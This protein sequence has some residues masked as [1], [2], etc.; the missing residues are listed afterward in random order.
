MKIKPIQV[1]LKNGKTVFLRSAVAGDAEAMLTHLVTTHTEAYRNM[2]RT[3]D[4]WKDMST[5]K[6][7]K[8]L[9][10]FES[11]E[12]KFMI[13]ATSEERIIGGLGF[14]GASGQFQQKNGGLGMSIQKEISNSGLGTQMMNL[15]IST[16]KKMGFHR[17]E[18]SVRTYNES[19]IALYEKVGFQ[20]VGTLKEIAFIDNEYVDEFSYQ[21]IL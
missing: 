11:S 6:E 13:V 1:Q 14:V 18:L 15:A 2:N 9:A 7:A 4:F 17:M 12:N 5:E 19:G 10:E 20:R 3:A 8:I 16:A 21:L